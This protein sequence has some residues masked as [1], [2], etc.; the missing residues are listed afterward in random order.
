ML[1]SEFSATGWTSSASSAKSGLN[2]SRN[3]SRQ[4]VPSG[5]ITTSPR[6]S[7]AAIMA[8]SSSLIL[9][10]MTVLIG[11]SIWERAETP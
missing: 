2:L 10:S 3:G 4:V 1:A 5:Q 9:L 11:E 6:R 8:L 7:S